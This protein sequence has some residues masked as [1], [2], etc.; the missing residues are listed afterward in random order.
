MKYGDNARHAFSPRY[1]LGVR[2]KKWSDMQAD[3]DASVQSFSILKGHYYPKHNVL[4][5]VV[6]DMKAYNAR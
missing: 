4:C 3:S 1:R 5:A 2:A 6:S